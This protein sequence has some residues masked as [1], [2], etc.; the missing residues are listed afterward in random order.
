MQTAQKFPF[1]FV[2]HSVLT[3]SR[4]YDKMMSR[5]EA[6]RPSAKTKGGVN[7]KET[8][9]VN[10]MTSKELC[11]LIEWLKSQGHT[12]AE[13][14]ECIEFVAGNPKPKQNE[15]SHYKRE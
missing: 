9:E 1:R 3:Y 12:E 7:M 14:I 6:N 10:N 2:E 4:V 8:Q 13:V 5:G 11:N 15:P